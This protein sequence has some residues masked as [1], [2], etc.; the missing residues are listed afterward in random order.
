[1]RTVNYKITTKNL[2]VFETTSLE[3]AEKLMAEHP[4]SKMKVELVEVKNP[5]PQMST[6]RL[7]WLKSGA[8]PMHPYK[9][10]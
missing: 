7:E 1:M 8:K 6:T 9:G 3:V 4:H 2:E 10:V 5:A